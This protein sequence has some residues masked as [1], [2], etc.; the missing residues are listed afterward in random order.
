MEGKH[1]RPR[2]AVGIHEWSGFGQ[3]YKIPLGVS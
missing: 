3:E 1:R 2:V